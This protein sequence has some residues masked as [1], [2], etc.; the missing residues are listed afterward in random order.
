MAARWPI[1]FLLALTPP[2]DLSPGSWMR[3]PVGT[4]VAYTIGSTD[5]ESKSSWSEKITLD[6]I[7]DRK[8]PVMTDSRNPRDEMVLVVADRTL[9]SLLKEFQEEVR[10]KSEIEVDGKPL[11]CTRTVFV[12]NRKSMTVWGS[13]DMK[14]PE[15]P[16]PRGG[17]LPGNVVQV[18]S[19]EVAGELR[20][21]ARYRVVETATRL[22]ILG[23]EFT[24]FVEEIVEET[25]GSAED[26][27]KETKRWLCADVPGHLLKEEVKTTPAKGRRFTL[28]RTVSEIHEPK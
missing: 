26:F 21:F 15:R 25:S 27:K 9:S 8:F 2:Q 17:R 22:T 16:G 23:K 19:L 13:R 24:C 10:E 5:G 1:L 7:G 18:E 12:N 14:C 6:G 11:P 28:T 4:R 3:F 20:E